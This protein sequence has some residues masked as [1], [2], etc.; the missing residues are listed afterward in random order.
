M[1]PQNNVAT[2]V[3]AQ[4]LSRIVTEEW[5]DEMLGRVTGAPSRN[6]WKVSTLQYPLF[7]FSFLSYIQVVY[8]VIR[9]LHVQ[10][11][12]TQSH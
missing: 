8:A 5:N 9:A 2:L 4:G 1:I 6:H 3:S 11:S 10:A 7:P 12:P